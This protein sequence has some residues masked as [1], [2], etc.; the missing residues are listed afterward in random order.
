MPLHQ[1]AVQ[2]QLGMTAQLFILIITRQIL[3]EQQYNIH[4]TGEMVPVIMLF[5]VIVPQVVQLAQD[6]LTHLQQAQNKNELVQ[7]N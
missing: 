6:L 1:V 4:G 5:Q 2:L 3:V 7:Y